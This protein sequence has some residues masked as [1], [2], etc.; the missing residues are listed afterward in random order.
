MITFSILR[1]TPTQF[2]PVV[3]RTYTLHLDDPVTSAGNAQL[4]AVIHGGD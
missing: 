3:T 1:F 4:S 2:F